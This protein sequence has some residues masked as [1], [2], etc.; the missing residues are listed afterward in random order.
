[1]MAMECGRRSARASRDST[2]PLGLPGKLRINDL[3]R[4]AATARERIARRVFSIPLRRISSAKPGIRRSATAMVASGVESRG[5]KPV[6]PVVRIKSK[7]PESASSRSCSRMLGG[8]S[9]MT[10]LDLISQPSSRQRAITA[11]P[12]LSSLFPDETESLMVMTAKRS[13]IG[14]WWKLLCCDGV[15]IRF[16]H[17]AH[18]FHQKA[19]GVARCGCT[20]GSIRGVEIDFKIAR[21]PEQNFVNG[22]VAFDV[23]G[24]RVA[25]LAGGEIE[26][27]LFPVVMNDE[28]AGLLPHFERLH[29]VDHAHL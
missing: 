28:A 19:S 17:Q 7:R 29:E 24:L 23:S 6:P 15:A 10:R 3:W 4:T 1:M 11:G 16:V 5:L 21:G 14:H 20:G 25:A 18:R 26:F 22:V 2:A 12:D 13:R 27:T 9:V 8:S